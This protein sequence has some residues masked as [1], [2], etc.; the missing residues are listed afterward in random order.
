MDLCPL[1]FTSYSQEISFTPRA[2]ETISIFVI[3][4]FV[5][6]FQ[7]YSLVCYPAFQNLIT[8]CLLD[9][10]TCMSQKNF[11][12]NM[13][14][15]ELLVPIF[16]L[17]LPWSSLILPMSTNGITCHSVSKARKQSHP[18]PLTHHMQSS[19]NFTD[20]TSFIHTIHRPSSLYLLSLSLVQATIS[21]CLA[22]YNCILVSRSSLLPLSSPLS[23]NSHYDFSYK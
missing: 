20:S 19:T 10:S 9:I 8:K 7:I 6:P 5:S 17:F 2:S 18:S 3:P 23:I 21:P 13:F 4:Q 12:I 15:I 22:E 1:P 14:K 11:K 16:T